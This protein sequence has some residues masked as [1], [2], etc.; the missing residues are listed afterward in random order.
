[1]TFLPYNFADTLRTLALFFSL[2]DT[3]R[4]CK[5]SYFDVLYSDTKKAGNLEFTGFPPLF[6]DETS[7]I[8]T[9]DNVIKSQVIIS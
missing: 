2:A 5:I 6:N 8:R 7:G 4:T 9:P 1:M 3:M